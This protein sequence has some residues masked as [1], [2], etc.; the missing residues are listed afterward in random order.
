MPQRSGGCFRSE[1]HPYRKSAGSGAGCRRDLLRRLHEHGAGGRDAQLAECV[2]PVSSQRLTR[3]SRQTR[4]YILHCLPAHR[5]E[6][7]T[8]EIIDG[9][10]SAVF[11]QAEN[12][13]HAQKALLKALL[14]KQDEQKNR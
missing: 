10:N 7:V 14:Y 13:L 5:E 2:C 6:E 12:R 1:N 9:P 8:S 11:Q 4:L 3:Q